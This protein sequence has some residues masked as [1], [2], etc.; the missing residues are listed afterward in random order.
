LPRRTW[1]SSRKTLTYVTYAFL[2]GDIF[3]LGGNMLFLW[4][5]GDNVE[6]ALG[7]VPLPGLLPRVRGGGRAG[8]RASSRRTQQAPLIGA[9]GARSPA[10]SPPI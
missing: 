9:S 7:H 4:V 10:S 1:S 5:F 2:H 3:H 8:A 6:D